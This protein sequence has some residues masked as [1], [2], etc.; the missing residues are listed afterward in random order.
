MNIHLFEASRGREARDST[1]QCATGMNSESQKR[2][3]LYTRHKPTHSPNSADPQQILLHAISNP[4]FQLKPQPGLQARSQPV[5]HLGPQAQYHP[6][7]LLLARCYPFRSSWKHRHCQTPCPV[8]LG[9]GVP[10]HK[11]QRAGMT[12]GET[13]TYIEAL[14][15]QHL[16]QSLSYPHELAVNQQVCLTAG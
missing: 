1:L 16:L 8:R 12:K 13:G 9:P 11:G 15:I 2:Q 10:V 5:Y 3:D 4:D 7:L 6:F 14:D